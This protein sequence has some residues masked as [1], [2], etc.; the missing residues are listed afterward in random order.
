[1]RGQGLT[2]LIN[3]PLFAVTNRMRWLVCKTYLA[4]LSSFQGCAAEA[5]T[6]AEHTIQ[7]YPSRH[8][9]QGQYRQDAGGIRPREAAGKVVRGPEHRAWTRQSRWLFWRD[10]I[11]LSPHCLLPTLGWRRYAGFPPGG[12]WSGCWIDWTCFRFVLGTGETRRFDLGSGIR[13]KGGKE[14]QIYIRTTSWT[15]YRP[16]NVIEDVALRHGERIS[17]LQARSLKKG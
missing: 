10:L 3:S 9:G 7:L 6:T 11:L 12:F 1:M 8:P 14:D 17:S 2:F 4:E 13:G 16:S 15:R 5:S